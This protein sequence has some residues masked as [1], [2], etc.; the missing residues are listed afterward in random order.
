MP[1]T[2]PRHSV[3]GEIYLCQ[4]PF[5]SGVAGKMRPALVLFD[6]Q[7]DAVICRVTSVFHS[8]ILDITQN[9]WQQAGLLKP[10]VARLDR[11][12]TAER[13]IFL[14]RLGIVSGRELAAI[15]TAW[16]QYMRL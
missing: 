5:A 16:N 8:G 1:F 9:D 15:K 6:L 10:S 2:T 7:H 13:N 3:L 11:L 4:F 14:K 12:V